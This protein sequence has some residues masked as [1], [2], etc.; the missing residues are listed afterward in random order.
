[1]LDRSL[2]CAFVLLNGFCAALLDGQKAAVWC[3]PS[4]HKVR[5]VTVDRDVRL[6]VLD[7]GGSGPP[8]V[9]LTGLGGTAHGFDDFAPKLRQSRNSTPDGLVGESRAPVSIGQAV[10]AGMQKYT[11]IRVPA[12][13]IFA[14]PH[15]MGPWVNNQADP[16]LREAYAA[17]ETAL[18]EK[19]AKA[20]E[21]GV[22][23][24]RVV[25]IPYANH[26]IFMSN[27]RDVL[28]EMRAFLSGLH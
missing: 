18:V 26:L 13:V 21:N 17:R 12:L 3:D 15:D 1:M 9:L 6:E 2:L 24:A 5:F 4:T 10:L 7:W 22:P 27:E 14:V 19:Q 8:L 20:F 16:A 28:Q 25:R 11:D 23:S